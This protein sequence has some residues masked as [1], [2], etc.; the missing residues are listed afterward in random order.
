MLNRI[1]ILDVTIC[2]EYNEHYF[3][4][5]SDLQLRYRTNKIKETW[6]YPRGLSFMSLD[7]F[8]KKLFEFVGWL[9]SLIPHKGLYTLSKKRK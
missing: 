3:V 5:L 8:V 1:Q 9:Y 7:N 6:I 4:S 2:N